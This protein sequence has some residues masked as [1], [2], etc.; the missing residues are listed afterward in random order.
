M[1]NSSKMSWNLCWL[2]LTVLVLLLQQ[3]PATL[4]YFDLFLN[5]SEVIKLMGIEVDLFYVRDGAINDYAMSFVIPMKTGVDDLQFSWQSRTTYPLP[6]TISVHYDDDEGALQHPELN[7]PS[8]GIIPMAVETFTVHL[9]CSGNVTKE[10]PV[11][12]HLRVEGPPKQNDTKLIIRRNK[13][14]IKGVYPPRQR[15]PAAE[16]APP[17]G[18]ALLGAA[19][20][21]LGLVLVVGLIASAMY[22][23][24]RKQIRQDSLHTSFTTA[25]Y[26]SHQ[27]VFIRLDPLGRPPSANSGS[28]ATIASLNKYPISESK[29]S[30]FR[31]TPSP[32][33]YA[34][35]LL[36]L[37]HG[38][39]NGGLATTESVYAKP[40]SVCPSRVSYYASS[41][42]TQVYS[43][44]TPAR[45][46][47]SN[48][49]NPK[50]KLR[51]IAVSPDTVLCQQL[52]QEG[53]YGRIFYG[54]LHHPLGETRDV[55]IK[56]VVDGASLS[57]VAYLLSE[58]STLCGVSHPNIL[59]P[60]AAVTELSGPPKVAYPLATK[61]NLKLYLQS[62]REIGLQ[63]TGLSLSTR[64]L[65][66]FG[67]QVARGI[68]HLHSL[69]VLHKDIATRNCVLDSEQN[70]RVC[71]NALSRDIFPADY[72]CLGDNEN[73]P[74]KWMAL[75]TLEKKFYTAS[76]DIWS[77]G[78]LLWE[79]AT[80]AAMPF[81][82]VDSFELA[83]Y[84]RDG[85]RLAQPV[86]C[87]DEFYTVMSCCWLADYKQRPSFP[88]LI[89]YL[90]DFHEDLG[91]YV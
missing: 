74:I 16:I 21:A 39:S 76:S 14:C 63:G 65:V 46:I 51:R 61:G 41:Q 37:N 60:V 9:V 29:K 73:R 17:Q 43:L 81:E 5:H 1:V 32:S 58:G 18:P 12:I 82:E 3:L 78:V 13:I 62:C 33:P 31:S 28:Y 23:R 68:S 2:S 84:L 72:H 79:L 64:Q 6:Y 27:N 36:P 38:H 66:D 48:G 53:T 45:S 85:Y 44:S 90:H 40:E 35:A 70:V 56:T 15:M 10:V 88:Q 67:L 52:A 59:F 26:G 75:E 89:A 7:I 57:Q 50:D 86:N 8:S 25:A 20:C 19:A 55:L 54:V 77:L 4:G 24:A 49:S 80:L 30:W 69:G 47:H 34:T 71:D 83:A 11:G 91:K 87:P 42:L 22:V